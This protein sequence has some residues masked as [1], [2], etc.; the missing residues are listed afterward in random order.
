[1]IEITDDAERDFIN[2][3]LGK[4]KYQWIIGGLWIL[5]GVIVCEVLVSLTHTTEVISIM[6]LVAAGVGCVSLRITCR[7]QTANAKNEHLMNFIHQQASRR[8]GS[9]CRE[10]REACLEG[11]SC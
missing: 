6:P 11:D 2:A 9:H 8:L 7:S 4:K 1:M 3:V 10:W 5:E